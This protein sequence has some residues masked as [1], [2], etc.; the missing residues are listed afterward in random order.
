MDDQHCQQFFLDPYQP[1]QRHY[2]ALRAAFVERR[3]LPEIARQFG[4]AHGTLRNLVCQ[5][6]SHCQAGRIPPFL[7]HRDEDDLRL[8]VPRTQQRVP[9]LL[10]SPIAVRRRRPMI[11][12]YAHA[13]PAF[14]CSCHS[15]PSSALTGLLTMP[16]IPARR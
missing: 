10:T 5:F 3:P 6:R 16:A 12:R 15:W 4:F 7:R 14:S 11:V 13:L 8:A 2:E 1:L 9:K